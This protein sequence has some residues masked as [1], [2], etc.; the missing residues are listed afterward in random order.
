MD[1]K[2]NFVAEDSC[3]SGCDSHLLGGVRFLDNSLR[4]TLELFLGV[5]ILDL[6]S[7]CHHLSFF[8]KM[9]KSSW[10]SKVNPLSEKTVK[11]YIVK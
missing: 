2:R 10:L 8:G 9:S 5:I 11:E 1:E 7:T 4:P 3:T 6:V